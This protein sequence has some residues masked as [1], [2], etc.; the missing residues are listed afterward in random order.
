V[1]LT[2]GIRKQLQVDYEHNVMFDVFDLGGAD[3]LNNQKEELQIAN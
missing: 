3:G 2:I 1:E